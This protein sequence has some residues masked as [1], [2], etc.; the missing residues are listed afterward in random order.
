MTPPKKTGLG[1]GL[2]SLFSLE[3]KAAGVNT[4]TEISIV[5]IDPNPNQPRK[6]FDSEK[7]DE[8]AESIRNHGLLQPLVVTPQGSR[9]LL[10]AG[11][12]R[13]RAAR[14]AGLSLVPAVVMNLDAKSIAEI[15]L[16]ENLQRDD[17]N[18][19]EEAEGIA[20]LME[21]FAITQEDAAQRLG[22]SRPAIAN[23]LRLL[24]LTAPVKAMVRYGKL[25]AGHARALAAIHD[26]TLQVQL[27]QM[28]IEEEL[29]VRQLE[30]TL[31]KLKKQSETEKKTPIKEAQPEFTELEDRLMRALGTRV[32][33]KGNMDKGRIILEYFQR[34]DLE[35]IFEIATHLAADAENTF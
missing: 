22:R 21:Q 29:S 24:Q 18:P 34:D 27:A 30:D 20:Q 5:D 33:V 4:P 31:R 13:W 3:Q 23:A 8:L 17:L 35:R 12:R 15:A 28:T 32:I 10:V 2:E 9:Y 11:E 26:E 7:L 19:L 6:N 14:L 1:K 25:S 16:V